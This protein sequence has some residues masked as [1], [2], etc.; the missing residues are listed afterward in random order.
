MKD[1]CEDCGE[2]WLEPDLKE[3]DCMDEFYAQCEED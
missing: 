2:P 3:C 1:Y